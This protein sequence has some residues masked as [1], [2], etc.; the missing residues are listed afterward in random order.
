MTRLSQSDESHGA[1]AFGAML[2]S[3]RRAAR[4]TLEELSQAS[5]VSV[6]ALGDMERGRSRGPQRRTVDALA[7]ALKLDRE[8]SQRLQRLADA[9]RERGGPAAPPYLLRTV[10]DLPDGSRN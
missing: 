2:R 8:Q 1:T 7:A 6:R 9:G 3:L 4:L 5:G 10:P